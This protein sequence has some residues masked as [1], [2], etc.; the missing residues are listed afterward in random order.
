MADL[1][2]LYFRN[3]WHNDILEKYHLHYFSAV[4]ARSLWGWTNGRPN[5][6]PNFLCVKQRV[7]TVWKVSKNNGD[8]GWKFGWCSVETLWESKKT[9]KKSTLDN[10]CK[11]YYILLQQRQQKSSGAKQKYTCGNGKFGKSSSIIWDSIIG[12]S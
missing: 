4:C 2:I 9:A 7:D 6:R 3:P 1:P 8:A 12:M 5:G 10:F 11:H